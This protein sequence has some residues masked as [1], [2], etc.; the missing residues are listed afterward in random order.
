[1]IVESADPRDIPLVSRPAI[2]DMLPVFVLVAMLFLLA[3]WVIRRR[4][5]MVCSNR[6]NACI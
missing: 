4:L 6:D 3:E 2:G 5:K 1:M